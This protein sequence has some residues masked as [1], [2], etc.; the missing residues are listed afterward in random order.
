MKKPVLKKNGNR[1]LNVM[2]ADF[3]YFNRHTLH[4]QYT[5]LSIGLIAQYAKQ[6]FGNDVDVSLFKNVD[7]FLEQAS[8]N[9]PDVVGLSIYYWNLNQNQYVVD[10]L[11][12]KFGNKVVIV[13]GGPC[14]DTDPKEQHKYLTKIFP[15]ANALIVNEGEIGFSNIIKKVLSNKENTFKNPIDGVVFL[16]NNELV[17][18]LQLG[19]TLD[20]ATMGSPY[21]SGLMDDFMNS[22]YHPLIQSSRFCPYTCA[23]CVSGKNR[24]KLRGYPI[25]QVEEELRYVSKKY[26]DRPHHVMYLT[27]ENFGIL[28]RDVEIAHIIRKCKEDYGF[29]QSVFFY[30]DKRFTGTSRSVIEILGGLN[31]Y[32]MCLSLQTEN[33]N[34]LKAINRVNV[35]AEQIDDAI[36]WASARDIPASTELIFGLPHETRDGFID[37]MNRS[38]GRGFDTV[39][40]NNLFVMDGIELNRPDVRKKYGI[41]TK[42]RLLGTNYGAHNGNF[43]AEHEEVVVSSNSFSYEDFLEVRSL[44]FIHFAVFS[45]HFQK[46]FFQFIRNQ[47]VSLAEFFS[48][49][50]NPDRNIKWPN[51]YINFLEDF[52]SV[53]EGELF[54]NRDE[55]VAKAKKIFEANGNDVGDPTRINVNLG[56]RLS[57]LESKWVKPVLMHHLDEMMGGLLS[58]DDRNLANSLIDLAERERIS[59][60][61]S[62]E[63]KP[64]NIA[65]DVINWRKTKYKKSLYDLKMPEKLIKFSV[66]ESRATQVSGFKK[67]FSSYSDKD[68]YSVAVDFIMP[69]SCLLHVLSYD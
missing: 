47:G 56:A 27:D 69:R 37:L 17:K 30:N 31:Q 48:R 35:T 62:G 8:E 55:V 16:K 49:F 44:N 32:G 52:K 33:P 54:D 23:F 40:V 42:Y 7:K 51:G 38:I 11:R 64:L 45:L 34:T 59:L 36:S 1:S 68:Y 20:L 26:S 57:Y 46:W 18:G 29:P 14:I 10:Q 22:D 5:P 9:P 43:L 21:L 24:G 6:Q 58:S 2:F 3:C 25:E 61:E 63:K 50:M 67:R 13:L 66:D 41:K 65:F 28:K 15:Q 39:K 12:K 60:R 19:L 4:S 53:V